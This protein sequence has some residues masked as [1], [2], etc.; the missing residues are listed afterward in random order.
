MDCS[1]KFWEPFSELE[2]YSVPASVFKALSI[3]VCT[4]PVIDFSALVFTCTSFH[5]RLRVT[6]QHLGHCFLENYLKMA[7]HL[8][9]QSMGKFLNSSLRDFWN[10]RLKW[11]PL[12]T[13]SPIS[14]RPLPPIPS[15]M[16]VNSVL[17]I[18]PYAASSSSLKEECCLSP[19]TVCA[20]KALSRWAIWGWVLWYLL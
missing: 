3:E 1:Y 15:Y 20:H 4:A 13:R 7:H 10:S 12:L 19:L 2:I 14:S 18:F 16:Q 9:R 8:E 11:K 17:D 6:A 5:R